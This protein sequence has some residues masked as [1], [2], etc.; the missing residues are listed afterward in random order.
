MYQQQQCYAVTAG[1][2]LSENVSTLAQVF[3][4][5]PSIP[6]TTAPFSNKP[7]T[8]ST[9]LSYYLP[10]YNEATRLVQLYLEQAPWF[11]GAVTE[12]QIEQEI[13]PMWYEEELFSDKNTSSLPGTTISKQRTG[14]SHD[15]ALLFM[16]FCFGSL[17]DMNLPA[18]PDNPM[19]DKFYQ[20]TKVALT[21]DP[22]ASAGVFLHLIVVTMGMAVDMFPDAKSSKN[23]I[24]DRP[25]SV[26]PVQTFSLMA[27]YEGLCSG[28]NSIES[29]WVLFGLATKLSQS[30]SRFIKLWT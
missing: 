7:I 12:K 1:A 30:V 28:E 17:T 13:M 15:L 4:L 26:A 6:P 22:N 19:S 20:L 21:L 11:F 14:T 10:P 8:F 5:A 9:L 3:P 24:L 18:P 16:L 2:P 27:I 23:G 29:T 25:P